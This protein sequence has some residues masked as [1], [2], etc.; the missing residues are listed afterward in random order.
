MRNRHPLTIAEKATFVSYLLAYKGLTVTEA[1]RLTKA[2]LAMHGIF[3]SSSRQA[4]E[5]VARDMGW[6]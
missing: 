6:Q 1:I 4:F 5:H 3:S 2:H